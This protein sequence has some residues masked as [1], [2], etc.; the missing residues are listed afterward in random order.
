MCG[1]FKGSLISHQFLQ[2]LVQ[3]IAGSTF[4]KKFIAQKIYSLK[5]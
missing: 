5:D 4:Q 3:S 1:K 2:S